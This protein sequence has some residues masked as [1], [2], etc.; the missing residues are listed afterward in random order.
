MSSKPGTP[1]K[2]VL[3]RGVS[4]P[5]SAGYGDALGTMSSMELL[6]PDPGVSQSPATRRSDTS[7]RISSAGNDGR[8]RTSRSISLQSTKQAQ[9]TFIPVRK[10]TGSSLTLR[11]SFQLLT[12][13]MHR[14]DMKL[15]NRGPPCMTC[16]RHA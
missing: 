2:R 8:Q 1:I 11:A 13:H 10:R 9:P 15:L 3:S 14:K 7:T 4:R 12:S 16:M 6:P 5:S